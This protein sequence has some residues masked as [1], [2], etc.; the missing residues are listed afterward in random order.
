MSINNYVHICTVCYSDIIAHYNYL[1]PRVNTLVVK[2]FVV[3]KFMASGWLP[4]IHQHI[5]WWLLG[6]CTTLTCVPF[7]TMY[8]QH[9]MFG[10]VQNH[11]HHTKS[12]QKFKSFPTYSRLQHN[13]EYFQVQYV[14]IVKRWLPYY[15]YEWGEIENLMK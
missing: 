10:P 11:H 14:Y 4:D 5:C 9:T 13:I 8:M 15:I 7:Y 6:S 2:S 1:A 12:F 3:W